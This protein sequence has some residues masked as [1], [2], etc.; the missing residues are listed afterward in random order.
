MYIRLLVLSHL[1]HLTSCIATKSK[2]HFEISSAIA[3]SE[4][5]LL[6][7]LFQAGFLLG[8]IP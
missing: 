3:L 7:T 2:L 4:K 1:S 5:A 6:A 8:L